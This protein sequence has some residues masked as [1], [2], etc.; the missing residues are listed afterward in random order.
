MA[1]NNMRQVVAP[2]STEIGMNVWH[3]ATECTRQGM[4]A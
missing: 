1:E 2:I 4:V 3:D